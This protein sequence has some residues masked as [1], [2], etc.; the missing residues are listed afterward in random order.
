MNYK[1]IK[2]APSLYR[3]FDRRI[4]DQSWFLAQSNSGP[5]AMGEI[6][7]DGFDHRHSCFFYGDAVSYGA[8]I[9][10]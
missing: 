7:F 3:G 2:K 4:C 6:Y 1:K 8:S 9:G 5:A 10:Q